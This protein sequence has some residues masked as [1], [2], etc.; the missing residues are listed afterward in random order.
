MSNDTVVSWRR[1]HGFRDP[2]TELL[3]T[4]A[5]R[6]IEAAVT[7]EFEEY[8]SGFVQEKLPDGRQRVVR[9]GHLPERKILT[10][11]GEVDVR[12][13]TQPLGLPAPFR[14]SVVPPYVRR[15][16]RCGDSVA[17]PARGVHRADASGG[18]RAGG[19]GGRPWA[20]GERGQSAQ[21]Q[22]GRGVPPVVPAAARRRVGLPVGGRSTADFAATRAAVRAVV[23]PGTA[24][25]RSTSAIRGRSCASP[26]ERGGLL[27]EK[28]ASLARR[29]WPWATGAG[30]LGGAVGSVSSD[31]SQRAGCT[32]PGTSCIPLARRRP[33]RDCTR[34]GSPEGRRVDDWL[35]ATTT[36]TPA[37]APVATDDRTSRRLLWRTYERPTSERLAGHRLAS[38]GLR[39]TPACVDAYKIAGAQEI[40]GPRRQRQTI[41]DVFGFDIEL[42]GAPPHEQPAVHQIGQ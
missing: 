34:S 21:A 36:S 10:G 5:R 29:D 1:Q 27:E 14:S 31:P 15:C 24:A 3:R 39:H 20:V 37:T 40:P 18:R 13:G 33:S 16:A 32:R 26:P 23:I 22:L 6:L 7:A 42:R 19:R 28:H 9:N 11:L 35:K 30:V 12:V 2:L 17:V 38:Q 25:A 8:L 41:R 4:G